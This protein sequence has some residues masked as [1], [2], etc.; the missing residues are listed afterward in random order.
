MALPCGTRNCGCALRSDTLDVSGNGSAGNPWNLNVLGHANAANY[1]SFA[2]V[3]ERD[4]VLTAPE[5]GDFALARDTNITYYYTGTTW[6]KWSTPWTVFTPVWL[7]LTVGNGVSDGRYRYVGGEMWLAVNF[8]FGST[9]S[10]TGS[11]ILEIPDGVTAL[12][13]A[14]SHG[15]V[16]MLDAG[17]RHHVGLILANGTNLLQFFQT[18][19]LSNGV[20]TASAP[21][22]WGVGDII[23]TSIWVRTLVM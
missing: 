22:V 16:W 17:V 7:N 12:T 3:A 11:L 23:T 13:A 2:N 4:A 14:G 5:H 10:M 8:T 9:S 15:G 21:F 18:E 6:R 19:N 20:I 1:Y